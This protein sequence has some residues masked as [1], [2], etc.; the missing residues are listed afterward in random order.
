MKEWS[1]I[2]G[3]QVFKS[4]R[5]FEIAFRPT[6]WSIRKFIRFTKSLDKFERDEFIEYSYEFLSDNYSDKDTMNFVQLIRRERMYGSG[7]DLWK[8]PCWKDPI[9]IKE[10]S[11]IEFIELMADLYK[12][13]IILCSGA[14]LAS[15]LKKQFHV[16]YSLSTIKDKIYKFESDNE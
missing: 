14:K 2:Y 15:I 12:K 16:K 10:D 8:D 4:P 11:E 3:D 1:V 7:F 6:K 5:D 9:Y 13:G